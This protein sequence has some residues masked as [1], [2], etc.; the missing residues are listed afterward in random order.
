M[1]LNFIKGFIVGLGAS[2]PLGPLGV[3]CV[4]KTL[5]KGRNSGFITGL[6]A[7]V[8]DTFFAAFAILSLA[9]IQ[10]FVTEYETGVLMF[11]GLAVVIIAMVLDRVTQCL[12]KASPKSG[13][14]FITKIKNTPFLHH[15]RKRSLIL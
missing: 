10:D 8:S 15:F 4:Q 7:A 11:G 3:M 14:A 2:I 5:S 1:L 12:G 9:L 6:G 13:K